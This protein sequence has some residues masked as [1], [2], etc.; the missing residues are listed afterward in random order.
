M[1][2]V[3]TVKLVTDEAP[4]PEFYR[5]AEVNVKYVPTEDYELGQKGPAF[6]QAGVSHYLQDDR[7]FRYR[8]SYGYFSVDFELP[9][10][11]GSKPCTF[12]ESLSSIANMDFLGRSPEEFKVSRLDLCIEEPGERNDVAESL[13]QLF[14]SAPSPHRAR[15]DNTVYFARSSKMVQRLRCYNRTVKTAGEEAAPDGRDL[16]RFELQRRRPRVIRRQFRA[17]K[18]SDLDPDMLQY[19]MAKELLPLAGY[20]IVDYNKLVRAGYEGLAVAGFL[21]LRELAGERVLKDGL[22][23]HTFYKLRK[24]A[25]GVKTKKAT[26]NLALRA[27]RASLSLYRPDLVDGADAEELGVVLERLSDEVASRRRHRKSTAQGP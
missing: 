14:K 25:A 22:S 18:V 10:V 13:S 23:K 19:V 3:D 17:E 11:L 24:L 9:V 15:F 5:Y 8:D 20:K 26:P 4:P 16:L 21:A 2:F 12:K 6:S 27:L 1:P 7:G